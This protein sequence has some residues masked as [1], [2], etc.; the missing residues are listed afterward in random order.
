[1]VEISMAGVSRKYPLSSKL[2]KLDEGRAYLQGQ[3]NLRLSDFGLQPKPKM[4]GMIKVEDSVTVDFQL[5]IQAVGIE[6]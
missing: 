1:M 6:Q 2:E 3:Q 5:I 4:L